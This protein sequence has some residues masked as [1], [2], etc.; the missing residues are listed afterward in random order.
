ML[1]K[2]H[3]LVAGNQPVAVRIKQIQQ[4]L[5]YLLPLLLRDVLVGLV[6]QP[7]RPQHLLRLPD[8]VGVEVVQRE[9]GQGIVVVGVVFFCSGC[10][11][12]CVSG[13]GSRGKNVSKFKGLHAG[14]VLLHPAGIRV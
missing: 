14:H 4:L 12:E 11:G 1:N 5:Q 13:G 10:N 2:A 9:E 3:K 7:I 8:A 6:H